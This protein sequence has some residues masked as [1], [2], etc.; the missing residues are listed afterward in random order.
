MNQQSTL[1][2]IQ[3]QPLSD[4][5]RE[6]FASQLKN[7]KRQRDE[8]EEEEK[9]KNIGPESNDSERSADQIFQDQMRSA[10]PSDILC[11]YLW[12]KRNLPKTMLNCD[13]EELIK[14]TMSM[15]REQKMLILRIMR[16]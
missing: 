13:R 12:F 16:W 2:L 3:K 14:N 1:L 4:M 6:S 15:L 11:E 8:M 9:R 10:T 5:P 7:A